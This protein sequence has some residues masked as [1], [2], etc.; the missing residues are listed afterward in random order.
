MQQ[1][2]ET[3]VPKWVLPAEIPF[4]RMK[5][6]DLEECVYWLLDAMGGKDLEWR[7][8]GTGGGA[9]DGGRDIAATFYTPTPEG[10]MEPEHWWIECKGRA[11][12][13]EPDAVKNAVVN[14]QV[15]S[16]LACIVVV[17]N[18]VFSNPTRDWVREWQR[19]H[20]RPRVKLWDRGT[21]EKLISNQPGVVLRLFSEALSIEGRLEAMRERF[22]NRLEYAPMKTL[23]E[24]WDARSSLVVGALE[25]FALLVNEFAH[26]NIIYRPWAAAASPDELVSTLQ[27]GL[28]NLPYLVNRSLRLG[29]ENGP[30]I[31]TASHLLLAALQRVSAE[32]IASIV[33][34][35]I[36]NRGDREPSKEVLEILLLPILESLAGEMQDVCGS[37]CERLMLSDRRALEA[38]GDPVETYWLRF[39]PDGQKP[40]DTPKRV[41][42]LE[43]TDM[44]CKVGFPVDKDRSCPLYAMDP[45]VQNVREFLSVIERVSEFRLAEARATMKKS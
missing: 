27:L 35:Q 11:S 9:A 44:P 24:F 28:V 6:H 22:W 41:L 5:G 38:G 39:D 43:K 8:G 34:T 10:E 23:E 37:N 7:T 25:Q 3:D 15:N 42:L 30:I 2:A 13:V 21:L 16:S 19:S 12:T 26:G 29:V 18:S 20:P 32:Q 1:D 31:K 14:A 45:T 33:L 17:T 4:D 36:G 40:D